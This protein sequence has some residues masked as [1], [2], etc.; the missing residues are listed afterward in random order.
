MELASTATATVDR[1]GFVR[2]LRLFDS[3][4]IVAGSMIG[5]GIFIVS[6]DIARTVGSPGGL[7]MVWLVTG[8]LTAFAA[9]AYGELAGMY[10]QAGGQYIYLREAYSPLFGFLYGW[11]LFLV[12]QTGTI[13]AVAVAFARFLG[14]LAP[15]VSPTAWIIK[16]INLSRDYAISLSSQQLVGILIIVLLT[17]LNTRGIKI[18]KWV[19]NTFTSIKTL[20]LIALILFC[21]TVGAN[22]AAISENFGN[23]WTPRGVNEIKPDFSFVPSLSASAGM[24]G[25]LVAFCVAQ[26]GS[27]FSSDAWNNVTFAAGE[28]KDAERTVAKAMAAGV[29]LVIVLYVLANVAYLVAMP[30]EQIQHAPDDR[31]ATAALGKVLGQRG[32]AV[33]ALA[34]LF[35]TFGCNN[36]LILAGARVY[37]AM[38]RDGLFFRS[39]G[40]L[41]ARHVPSMGLVL[42]GVWAALLVLPRTRSRDAA[43]K[44]LLDAT[45][46]EQYGNLYN[47]LL[48]YVV[49]SVLIFY[50]LTIAGIF[51]LRRKHPQ[52]WRPY[53][54]IGYPLVPAIYVVMATVIMVVLLLYQTKTTWPGL[55]IVL[56]GIPAYAIWRRMGSPQINRD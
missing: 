26:V 21:V 42:Q 52:A 43:G 11:T 17:A 5:S 37:Y 34:I 23:F 46:M 40:R 53:R 47:D 18:G 39:I 4:M 28:V 49:F 25:I 22:K 29:G 13:A 31:V 6:A 16:P 15:A 12:I 51:V 3:T 9:L 2:E 27:L 36:G 45:G 48:S 32:A 38:A 56:T 33:M 7:L 55:A 10:P 14:V 24:L 20:S 50:V 41:N 1:T 44:V 35:S 19:Q 8:L 30:L 54:A